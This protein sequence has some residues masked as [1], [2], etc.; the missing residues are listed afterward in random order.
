MGFGFFH[1]VTYALEPLHRVCA[2]CFV[3]MKLRD[4]RIDLL[5]L[6]LLFLLFARLTYCCK[7]AGIF[8]TL[9]LFGFSCL[10]SLGLLANERILFMR[11]RCV[12]I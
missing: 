1:D 6:L 2:H 4:S 7:L 11:E 3:G 10:L 8:L 12:L 5:R 9:A